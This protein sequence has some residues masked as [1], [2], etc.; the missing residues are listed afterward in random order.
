MAS[1][2]LPYTLLISNM[3]FANFT[4]FATFATGKYKSR[5][6]DEKIKKS[7][8]FRVLPPC[9]KG[10]ALRVLIKKSPPSKL[11]SHVIFL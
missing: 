3:P 2:R 1:F 6:D 4:D 9:S 7:S 5:F 8:K 11:S 10:Q